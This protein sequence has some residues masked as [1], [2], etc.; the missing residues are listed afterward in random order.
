MLLPLLLL[1]VASAQDCNSYY[2]DMNLPPFRTELQSLLQQTHFAI[3][4]EDRN[5]PVSMWQA[6]VDVDQYA[7]N[8]TTGVQ[9]LY[10]RSVVDA[11]DNWIREHLWPKSRGV[12]I[13]GLDVLD[14]HHTFAS[15]VGLNV[16]RGNK[17]FGY[18]AGCSAV[19]GAPEGTLQSET[20]FQ[21]TEDIR[22]DVARALFYMDLRYSGGPETETNLRL[23][24][25]PTEL[26][27]GYLSQL[28]Q[29]HEEDPVAEQE[30]RRN[31]RICELW[32][33]N[34]NPF[35]DYEDLAT[36]FFGDVSQRPPCEEQA[37]EGGSSK[38]FDRCSSQEY[39]NGESIDSMSRM[40]LEDLLQQT[41]R[42]RLPYTD[43]DSDDTWKALASLYPGAQE[44]TVRLWYSQKDVAASLAG[45]TTGWNREHLWPKSLGVD[46]S[47][48]DYTDLHHLV[49]AD[50]NVNAARSNKF[51]GSCSLG[52]GECRTPAHPEA[53][54]DTA[55][56][57][58]TFLPPATI[59]GDVARAMFYMDVR[60]SGNQD[61]EQDLFL[62]DCP[63]GVDESALGYLSELLQWHIDDPVS[64]EERIRNDEICAEWQGNRNPFVDH[65]ELVQKIFGSPQTSILYDCPNQD[66]SDDFV[67]NPSTQAPADPENR[68]ACAPAGSIMPIGINAQNPDT[69]AFVALMDIPAGMNIYMTDNAW[70]GT[71][72]LTNE[73]TMQLVIP[74]G[75]IPAGQ[76][77]GYEAGD[78]LQF[79]QW[80]WKSAGGRF[81]LAE[82]GDT[83]LVYCEN[84]GDMF[85]VSGV[86]FS[87][88]EWEFQGDT[89]SSAFPTDIEDDFAISLQ[90]AE[91]HKYVGPTSGSV[92][93]LQDAISNPWN[94]E[95][96]SS[97]RY[98]DLASS[99]VFDLPSDV[100]SEA[101]DS[102]A[103]SS[104]SA[105]PS[106]TL[107]VLLNQFGV[108]L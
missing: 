22:G 12:G 27:L 98:T 46:T 30:R 28:L 54:S 5:D 67:V 74:S 93:A 19:V 53:T 80:S 6:L 43:R 11:D 87:G 76:V 86:S 49:P 50:W 38:L 37:Q 52:E 23:S 95:S 26:E 96:T 91:S 88:S 62:T 14:L 92:S 103:G 66:E 73:G 56:T 18:C 25:C 72:F 21:V 45:N 47:G 108:L 83:I 63:D 40:Y 8:D 2:E 1:A 4:T 107:W 39:Y 78:N 29:W 34:R 94:W 106:A 10:S 99:F 35:I 60:Y 55:A 79:P 20:T 13:S 64:D 90:A 24:D 3:M 31:N 44:G 68:I 51:F 59:R 58:T 61:S 17:H 41:H 7:R 75:G 101:D 105:V 32:Q 77:F 85:T 48:D 16:A 84:G 15:N 9:L 36:H 102:P 33:G 57:T 89:S 71:E 42:R 69:V 97:Q 65:E 82:G 81:A 70:T 100:S 104:S